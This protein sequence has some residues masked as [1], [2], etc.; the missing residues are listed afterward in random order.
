M[1]MSGVYGRPAADLRIEYSLISRDI[2][3]AILPAVR[4][5]GI[6]VTGYHRMTSRASN[7]PSRQAPLPALATTPG[8]NSTANASHE[9]PA[10]GRPQ[11]RFLQPELGGHA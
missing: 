8:R 6:G 11:S 10:A 5:L 1:A 9:W 7:E 3:R 4:D 2:E